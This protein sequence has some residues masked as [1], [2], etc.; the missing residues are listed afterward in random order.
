MGKRASMHEKFYLAD[1]RAAEEAIE[2]L[3]AHGPMAPFEAAARA[4]RSR[5]LGNIIHFCRWRQ[6]ERFLEAMA[7]DPNPQTVH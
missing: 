1:S 2:L 5:D 6:I 7:A 3:A 4:S